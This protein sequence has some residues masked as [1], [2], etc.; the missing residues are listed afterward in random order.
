M[1]VA[2][3][4]PN[5]ILVSNEQLWRVSSRLCIYKVSGIA[6][7]THIPCP[8]WAPSLKAPPSEWLTD[9]SQVTRRRPGV[10]CENDHMKVYEQTGVGAIDR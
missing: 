10:R 1:P 4:M 8:N 6:S 5:P 2:D 3:K 9:Q 7:G